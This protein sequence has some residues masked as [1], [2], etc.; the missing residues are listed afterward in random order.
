MVL[1]KVVLPSAYYV[2]W[3]LSQY[4]A[5]CV[6]IKLTEMSVECGEESSRSSLFFFEH[7]SISVGLV[8]K[9]AFGG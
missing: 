5:D 4:V 7:S 9:A 1:L 2:H 8:L 6:V 3:F